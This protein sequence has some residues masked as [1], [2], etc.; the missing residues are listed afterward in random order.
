MADSTRFD[1]SV[2]RTLRLKR[3]LTAE[4]LATKAGITRATVTKIEGGVGNP[5]LETIESLSRVFHL[6]ASELIRLGEVA[7]CEQPTVKTFRQ[8][9]I[10]VSHIWFPDFEIFRVQAKSGAWKIAEPEHH[11][12]TAE[13]CLVLSGRIKMSVGGQIHELGPGMAIR[14]K[15]LQEHRFDVIEEA[16]FLLMH[17]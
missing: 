4:Q 15:A 7:H 16:E 11:E 2:I 9:G 17:H 12:N 1:F 14:F 5:T 8:K 3:G 10:E 6:T 13:V